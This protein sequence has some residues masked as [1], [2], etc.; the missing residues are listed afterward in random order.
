MRIP[1]S[2]L[3][4]A[5][6]ILSLLCWVVWY[7]PARVLVQRL[8]AIHAGGAPLTLDQANG[9]AWA[10]QSRWHWRGHAGSVS[11]TLRWHGLTPGVDVVING[12]GLDVAGWL[13]AGSDNLQV[14]QLRLLL[15]LALVLEGQSGVAADGEVTGRIDT[16]VWQNNRIDALKGQLH[17]GGGNGRWQ[18]QSASLPAMDARLFMDGKLA[19]ATVTDA[20]QQQLASASVDDK[21]MLQL[22]VYR[23]FAVALGMSEGKGS[24]SDVILKLGQPLAAVMK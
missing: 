4:L 20:Q 23:A 8:P 12:A 5:V 2:G 6:F 24:S 9:R 18:Q 11:W 22:K 3:L 13:S 21:Q 10:G 17:Y 15:P 16:L 14:A 7:L 19:R 1:R